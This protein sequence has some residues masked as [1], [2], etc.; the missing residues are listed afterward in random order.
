MKIAELMQDICDLDLVLPE[1][2]REYVW[3]LDQAK[4]LIDSLLRNYPTGSLLI[5][6]TSSPIE[7]KNKAVSPDKVGN[8]SVILDGQQ[9]LTTLYLLTQNRVPPYYTEDE[10]THDPR[11]LYYDLGT[12]DL[13]YFQAQRMGKDPAWVRVTS[14]FEQ[15]CPVKAVKIAKAKANAVGAADEDELSDRADTY[16]DNLTALQNVLVHDYPIQ[17]VPS[18]AGIEDAID[19]FDRVNKQ[20]T[21]LSEA[22]LALAHAAA[23]WPG[24]RAE[25]K[26]KITTLRTKG[27]TFDLTFMVRSLTVVVRGRALFFTVHDASEQELRDGWKRLGAILDY[28]VSVLPGWAYVHS[29]DDLSTTNVLI[30][31]IAFLAQHGGKFS[32]ETEI[33]QF[34][35]W[36]YAA[37]TWARY[38][39]QTD[40]RLEA[41]VTLVAK[42]T[43]PWNGLMEA[44][45]DQ[46]GRIEMKAADLVHDQAACW[47]MR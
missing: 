44:I 23:K 24:I 17:V 8:M 16:Q 35:R 1:F 9:R 15:P 36:L 38:T 45:L 39:G 21:R 30:T 34:R 29:T 33:R 47:A 4:V 3:T 5:W 11:D 27:F 12:R 42:T 28:L 31:P 37:A 20:G 41:D 7:I 14:C 46:R 2:Q 18:S 22:E 13:Q 43:S 10:I 25:M 6:K 40:Q 26:D 19:V 32:G